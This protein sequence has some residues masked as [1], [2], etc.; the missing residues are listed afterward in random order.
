MKSL[1]MQRLQAHSAG[2]EAGSRRRERER[3]DQSEE[4]KSGLTSPVLCKP[5]LFCTV[6][7]ADRVT[8]LLNA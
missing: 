7:S 4:R 3:A 2:E 6:G 1:N 8:E 5:P